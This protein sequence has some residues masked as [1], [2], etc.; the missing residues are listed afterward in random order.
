MK[1]NVKCYARFLR[2]EKKSSGQ[3]GLSTNGKDIINNEAVHVS[4]SVFEAESQEGRKRE[5]SYA[6]H[7][8][9]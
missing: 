6:A 2:I 4:H 7:A 3:L 5:R 8:I 9:N 1:K